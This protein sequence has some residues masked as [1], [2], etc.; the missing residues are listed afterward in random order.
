MFISFF[1]ELFESE[2]MNENSEVLPE[3]QIKKLEEYFS[4]LKKMSDD[5]GTLILK[6][7]ERKPRA[8]SVL[9]Q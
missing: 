3:I 6:A 5:L 1:D 7:E 4:Q 8:L 2:H 9:P